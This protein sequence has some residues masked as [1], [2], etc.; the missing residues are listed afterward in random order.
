MNVAQIYGTVNDALSQV[1]GEKNILKEDLSNLVDMGK[2]VFDTDNVDNYVKTMMNKIGRE[3]FDDRVY[4]GTAPKVM[5]D[6]FE[7]G[8]VTRVTDM[9]IP[10]AVENPAWDLTDGVNYSD[11]IFYQPKNIYQKFYNDKTTFEV[12]ISIAEMQIKES[13]RDAYEMG[14]FIGMIKNKCKM[15]MDIAFENLIERTINNFIASKLIAGNGVVD[16]LT[17]YNVRNFESSSDYLTPEQALEDI[18]FLKYMSKEMSLYVNRLKKISVLFN[19]GKRQ[20]FTPESA[21]HFIVLDEVA[22]SSDIYLQADTYHNEMTKL[23]GYETVPFWQGMASGATVAANTY[24][25]EDNSRIYVENELGT[26]DGKYIVGVMF[27]RRALGVTNYNQ[28]IKGNPA[29]K[30]EFYNEYYKEDAGFF[31][32]LNE[33]GIVFVLGI[34]NSTITPADDNEG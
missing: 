22:K 32:N 17:P 29:Q 13:F 8:S 15:A 33:N 28:R 7:F 4:E 20:K 5:M 18:S 10:D 31:N 14:A 19:V 23:P 26:V 25:L 16:L 2:E 6:A 34:D 3:V 24:A 9:D 1:L 21:L 12:D 30:G 11:N 27:D